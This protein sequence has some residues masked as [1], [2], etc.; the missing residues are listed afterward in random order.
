MDMPLLNTSNLEMATTLYTLVLPIK[1]IQ[2]VENSNKLSFF[3]E[4][5]EQVRAT[6]QKYYDREL[7]VEPNELFWARREI[8][9][10]MKNDFNS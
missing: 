5:T 9:T 2:A 8:L 7:R 3:F 1:G 4:D 10:R 6:M